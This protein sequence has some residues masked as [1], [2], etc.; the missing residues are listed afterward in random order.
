MK[1]PEIQRE[2]VTCSK[3]PAACQTAQPDLKSRALSL[4]YASLSSHGPWSKSASDKYVSISF[5]VLLASVSRQ[6]GSLAERSQAHF[7]LFRGLL[8]NA[9]SVICVGGDNVQHREKIAV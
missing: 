6:N 5:A 9:H 3:A 4:H 1:N 2:E 8:A 7:P